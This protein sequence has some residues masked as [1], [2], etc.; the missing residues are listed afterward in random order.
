MTGLGNRVHVF[1]DLYREGLNAL[2]AHIAIIDRTGLIV[3]VN[4]AW[5]EFALAN[6][7][8]PAKGV[9]VG[10]NYLDVCR[11]PA[12]GNSGSAACARDALEGL[13]AVLD[14]ERSHFTMEYPCDSPTQQR[15]YVMD[16]AALDLEKRAGAIVSHLDISARKQA[17]LGLS[18][19][20]ARFRAMFD[21]AAV[22]IAEI[23]ADGRWLRANAAL[24]RIVG[25]TEE[26][27]LSRT[28][29]DITHIEERDAEA[30]HFEVLR[31]G[32][33]DA[34]MIEKRLLRGDGGFV[35]TTT[36]LS[37]VRAPDNSVDY[38][39]AVVEDIS[40]RKLAEERQRTMMRELS[41]REKTCWRSSRPSRIAA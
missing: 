6:G 27:L 20:E 5:T 2:P 11:G 13:Q 8:D 23:A 38:F 16:I 22:G 12:T 18:A 37:C 10:A 31:S 15:W 39:L 33:A 32:G 9:A 17:E 35:W 30:A 34:C 28:T 19:S 40:E 41:H 21:H 26:D 29:R 14:G 1:P 4:R 36:S 25:R 7:G 24:L 3:L